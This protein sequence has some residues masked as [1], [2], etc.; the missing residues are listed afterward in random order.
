MQTCV[1]AKFFVTLCPIMKTKHLPII[2]ALFLMIAMTIQFVVSYQWEKKRVL[3]HIDYEME[4]AQKD[5]IFEIYDIQDAGEEMVDYINRRLDEP[6]AILRHTK[7]IVR[8]FPDVMSCY[9]SFRPGYYNDSDYWYCPVS[10][11]MGDSIVTTLYGDKEHDYF[12]RKW[13]KGAIQS[14]KGLYW[15]QA[16]HDEDFKDPICTHSIR[17]EKD[18]GLVCVIG[19]DFS[20]LWVNMMLNDIKPFDDAYCKLMSSDGSMVLATDEI[21]MP[22]Q[23]RRKVFKKND[24]IISSV[25]LSPVDMRLEIGVPKH[26]LW[27]S[28]W[29]KSLITL[30]VLLI[31]ILVAGLLIRQI[32]RD[33]A[34][35]ARVETENK[36]MEREMHIASRIQRGILRDAQKYKGRV[37]GDDVDVLAAL[38][39]MKEVGGDLYD[40]FRKGEDLFFIIGDVSGKGVPAAMFMSAT[41][42]LFRSAVRRLQSP[43][44]I[45]EEINSVLSDNNPSMMFVTAFIG[46]L[47]VPTGEMLYCNAGHL[48]PIKVQ[49]DKV[50][51]AKV[52]ILTLEPNIPMGYEGKFRFVE[53]GTILGKEDIL[54]LYTDGITEARNEKREM[55]GMKRWI[56]IVKNNIKSLREGN[57][58][59]ISEAGLQFVGK[60]D[61]TDDMT[62][63]TIMKT[64]DIQPLTM[65]VENQ[66]A[67]WPKLKAA[68][69]NY[70]L[71]AGMEKRTIKKMEVA[72]EEAVVNIV[73]YSQATEIELK[74]KNEELK[75]ILILSD[76]GVAFDPTAQTPKEPAQGVADRQIGG[77]GISLIRQI[78][79]GM[80]YRRVEDKNELTIIKHLIYGNQDSKKE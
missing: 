62:L 16:Y 67:Q 23:T 10:W 40:Y 17:V 75:I 2:S 13:Y 63:M 36:L 52:E 7:T 4:L 5:F 59:A 65:H 76:N 33:Q 12:Q 73:N 35:F 56:E 14:E 30:G 29:E 57:M 50:Q 25:M 39:P 37:T 61:P 34:A 70:A 58:E 28:I 6:E 71:C 11:R 32:R 15:S 46:R 53:Q 8:R 38:V 74:I 42:N 26:H 47:N 60:A 64:N 72:L 20:L 66:I 49:G 31:G 54:V 41:V 77:L 3:E 1:Y 9:V 44:A 80:R 22:H 18:G 21:L 79:D 19:L 78:A 48:S 68:F 45:M 43:K 55:L 51:G 24:W 27:D 69:H